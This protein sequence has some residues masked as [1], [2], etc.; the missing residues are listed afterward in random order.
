MDDVKRIFDGYDIGIRYADDAVGT[1]MNKLDDLGGL[2]DTAVL[3]S[4][5]HREAFGGLGVYADHKGADEATCHIPSILHR[6]G[7]EPRVYEGSS[8][9]RVPV[10]RRRYRTLTRL[11]G[12]V[13]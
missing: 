1:L 13:G 3:I 9:C 2:D 7:L 11:T 4:S 5:D 10:G 8:S 6:P 12:T